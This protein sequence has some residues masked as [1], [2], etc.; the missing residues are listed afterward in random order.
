MVLTAES[1]CFSR[2]E[3]QLVK[4]EKE[5]KILKKIKAI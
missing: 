5:R 4:V 1:T 3:C 2:V